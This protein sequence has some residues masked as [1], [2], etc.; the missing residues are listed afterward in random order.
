MTIWRWYV[1]LSPFISS[2]YYA[3]ETRRLRGDFIEV[4]KIF[5]GF[6][7][8]KTY[9]LFHYVKYWTQRS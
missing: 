7:D 2:S 1:S 3:L 8:A 9:R 6:D 4:F 5:E